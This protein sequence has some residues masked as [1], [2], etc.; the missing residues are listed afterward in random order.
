MHSLD[1]GHAYRLALTRPVSGAFNIAAEPVLDAATVARVLRTR[2]VAVPS[3]LVRGAARASWALRLQ[4]TSPGW[5]DMGV[6][7]PVMDVSRA[8]GELGWEPRL[9]ADEALLDLLA[10]LRDGAGMST[11]PLDPRTSGPLRVRELL[12]GVGRR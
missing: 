2:S 12:S 6:L 5:L 11:P 4:P 3:G 10:G 7:S 1:V 9:G 8:R